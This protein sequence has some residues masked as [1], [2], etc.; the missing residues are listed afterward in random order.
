MKVTEDVQSWP[1]HRQIPIH[2]T[3][4]KNVVHPI[5]F[6][7]KNEQG[8]WYQQSTQGLFDMFVGL[9]KEIKGTHMSRFMEILHREDPL[10]ISIQ[11][12]PAILDNIL[13]TLDADSASL[14]VTFN[15][16][17]KKTA[18]ASGM[19][20][21]LDYKITLQSELTSKRNQNY[22]TL[23]VPVTTLCPCSKAISNYGAH[24]QRSIITATLL[25]EKSSEK[26]SIL[27]L[28]RTLE[29][30]GSCELFGIIKRPD[31]KILT[32]KAFDNPKFVEDVVRDCALA[33]ENQGFK[34]YRV[35]SD[36]L[37]SIHNHSAYALIDNLS[38]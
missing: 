15:T 19:Q 23:N 31:E 21:F 33:I 37:E 13:T 32:E 8:E 36:N 35:S 1:D 26:I 20:S 9:P 5:L 38:S 11:T 27:Q 6:K 25:L 30:Q 10:T 22:L 3:G 7:D 34:H 29:A 14:Q 16:F 17:F 28:I 18:P 2:K 12:L 4:V 24:N